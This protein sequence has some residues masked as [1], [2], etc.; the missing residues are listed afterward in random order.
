[1]VGGNEDLHSAFAAGRAEKI[2]TKVIS[3]I[4]KGPRAGIVIFSTHRTSPRPSVGPPG[5]RRALSAYEAYR[6]AGVDPAEVPGGDRPS[7]QAT[8]PR[9]NG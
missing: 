8:K 7:L 5:A 4:K 6:K 3:R 2:S 1:M 9:P